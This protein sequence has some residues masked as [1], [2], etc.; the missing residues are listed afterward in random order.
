MEL[1]RLFRTIAVAQRKLYETVAVAN[2]C[3]QAQYIGRGVG[4]MGEDVPA[5]EVVEAGVDYLS[6]SMSNDRPEY[7]Q[8]CASGY[9][10]L[11]LSEGLGNIL[12][13]G[14]CNGYEGFYCGG[15][16]FG[17]RPDGAFLRVSGS[18]AS[19][20]FSRVY[21]IQAHVSRID[22]QS[23]VRFPEYNANISEVAYQDADTANSRLPEKRR[24]KLTLWGSNDGGSTLYIGSRKS[25]IFLRLYNKDAESGEEFYQNCWRYEVELHNE[26]ANS[27]ALYLY[28]GGRPQAR[29]CSSTVWQVFHKRGVTPPYTRESEE[30]ALLPQSKPDTDVTRKLRWLQEQVAPT[31]TLLKGLLPYDI[32]TEALGLNS[33]PR[34]DAAHERLAEWRAEWHEQ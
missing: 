6:L 23:T 1:G 17:R 16:F 14:K 19:R 4:V 29:A 9:D 11:R 10:T 20:V 13:E 22:V 34:P 7:A 3:E 12:K 33:E 28:E 30:N 15:V 25:D 21:S 27:A 32:L 2:R 18:L 26:A 31:V 24:R 5:Y 8:W